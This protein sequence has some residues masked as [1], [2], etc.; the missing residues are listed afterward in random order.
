MAYDSNP[1]YWLC[2]A[3]TTYGGWVRTVAN[4]ALDNVRG[5]EASVLIGVPIG[6]TLEP[7]SETLQELGTISSQALE[8]V[9]VFMYN[10]NSG[11]IAENDWKSI[12]AFLLLGN[13]YFR[14]C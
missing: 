5:T 11:Q 1:V 9:S 10:Y 7:L 3:S 6:R 8:G 12:D 13:V 14:F 2:T 4:Y